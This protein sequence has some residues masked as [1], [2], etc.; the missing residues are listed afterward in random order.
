MTYEYSDNFHWLLRQ[1]VIGKYNESAENSDQN[2]AN[3]YPVWMPQT[4]MYEIS[5]IYM[6]WV[7][8]LRPW[9]WGE[10]FL[11]WGVWTMAFC[12]K[13]ELISKVRIL[14]PLKITST[15]HW[16]WT[17]HICVCRSICGSN[18]Q[19]IIYLTLCVM[20]ALHDLQI[21]NPLTTL[22]YPRCMRYSYIIDWLIVS[23]LKLLTPP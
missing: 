22:P 15:N 19:G 13:I 10:H 8:R 20:Q 23:N 5:L 12:P 9:C 21:S 3:R 1:D 4:P 7:W 2:W 18:I 6:F 17:F 11:Y 14:S 16:R